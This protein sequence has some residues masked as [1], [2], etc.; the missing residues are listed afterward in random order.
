MIIHLHDF[1]FIW[2]NYHKQKLKLIQKVYE[3]MLRNLIFIVGLKEICFL[4][5]IVLYIYN[6]FLHI[7]IAREKDLK[8]LNKTF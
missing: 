8:F 7:S 5:F 3:R 6:Y 4:D 2:V 1:F